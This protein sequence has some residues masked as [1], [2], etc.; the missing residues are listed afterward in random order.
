MDNKRGEGKLTSSGTVTLGKVFPFHKM[1]QKVMTK[2]LNNI[3][4]L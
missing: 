2:I 1:K 3:N 4:V